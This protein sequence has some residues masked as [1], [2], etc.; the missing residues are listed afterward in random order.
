MFKTT[1]QNALRDEEQNQD[2]PKEHRTYYEH[3]SLTQCHMFT[4]QIVEFKES[5]NT[6]TT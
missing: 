3:S 1:Q 4:Y 6:P 5:R 2:Q